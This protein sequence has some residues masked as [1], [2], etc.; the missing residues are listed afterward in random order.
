[1]ASFVNPIVLSAL[2]GAAKGAAVPGHVMWGPNGFQANVLAPLQE[3][4][5]YRAMPAWAGFP[6]G[7]SAFT[8]AVD[9]LVSDARRAPLSGRHAIARFADVFAGGLM[10]E[11]AYR[12][13][14][15]LGAVAAH[16]MHNL[17]VGVGSKASGVLQGLQPP[18]ALVPAR[19]HWAHWMP[20]RRLRVKRR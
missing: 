12:R 8:F 3:E 1:M 15:F 9:H 2:F 6:P 7:L 10:Y 17:M 11:S 18:M 20:R 14:G 13:W 16:A 19:A 4:A 5:I